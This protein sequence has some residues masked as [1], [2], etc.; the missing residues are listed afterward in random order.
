MYFAINYFVFW[1]SFHIILRKM[2]KKTRSNLTN[3]PQLKIIEV[4]IK[5]Y[6]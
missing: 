3:G 6:E 2:M 5:A 1:E 4:K